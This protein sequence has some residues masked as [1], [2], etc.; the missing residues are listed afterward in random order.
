MVTG[1]ACVLR[2]AIISSEIVI[3]YRSE[4]LKLFFFLSLNFPNDDKCGQL[5]RIQNSTSNQQPVTP[6]VLDAT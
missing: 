5:P 6:L 3:T 4:I 2:D 1:E